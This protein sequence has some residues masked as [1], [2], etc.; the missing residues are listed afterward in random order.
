MF[1]SELEMMME[2]AVAWK[3]SGDPDWSAAEINP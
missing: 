2:D 1:A 3:R